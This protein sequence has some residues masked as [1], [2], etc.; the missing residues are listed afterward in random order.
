MVATTALALFSLYLV[1]WFIQPLLSA[2]ESARQDTELGVVPGPLPD[3][4]LAALNPKPIVRFGTSFQVP[5]GQLELERNG[6]SFNVMNFKNGP[7]IMF[8][9]PATNPSRG[10]ARA[11]D[12]HE[13]A[14][15]RSMFGEKAVSS[16]YDWEQ[17]ILEAT[18]DQIQWWNRS[19]DRRLAVLLN[20]KAMDLNLAPV[21][22]SLAGNDLRGFQ[23]GDADVPSGQVRIKLY[24]AKGR[25]YEFLITNRP[26][27]SPGAQ[28]QI[29]AFIASIRPAS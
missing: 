20:L 1:L 13:Q 26:G 25:I 11:N 29:N 19:N 18:P 5:W 6:T 7:A 17:A 24:D 8:F 27:D 9:N 23:I 21:I 2:R 4:E 16:S 15:M 28:K 10:M 3:T 22:Y 12:P 14:R